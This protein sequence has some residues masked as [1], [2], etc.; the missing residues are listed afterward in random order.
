[1]RFIVGLGNPGREY[2][3]TPHNLGFEVVERLAA[4]ARVRARE[5]GHRSRL[6]RGRLDGQ[7]VLLAQPQTS[8]NLS[9]PAV[10][11]L[12]AAE[13]LTPAELLVIADD[14]ALPWGRLRLRERG[15]AGGHNGLDSVIEALGTTEFL[16]LRL[17]V[18]P[19]AGRPGGDLA[20]YV[21][22][23]L[24]AEERRWAEEMVNEAVEAVRVLLREGPKKAMTRFNRRPEA[25]KA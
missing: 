5:R 19:P 4:L 17:G 13:K 20:D 18:Q 11:E 1:M 24:G 14:V 22:A 9:G 25:G 15:S 12:L 2:A 8:M 23:L 21:L 10:A 16:R 7:E 6:W 3:H